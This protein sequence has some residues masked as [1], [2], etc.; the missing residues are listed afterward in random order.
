MIQAYLY[1][2]KI[3]QK[4]SKVIVNSKRKTESDIGDLIH[5]DDSG[6]ASVANTDELKAEFLCK[7]FSSVFTN[8]EDIVTSE[9]PMTTVVYLVWMPSIWMKVSSCPS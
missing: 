8:E 4:N 9:L 3:I 1:A 5:V 7:A 2:A 6:N